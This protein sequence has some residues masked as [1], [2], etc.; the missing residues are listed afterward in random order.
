M[1]SRIT[2]AAIMLASGVA[3]SVAA[4]ITP[5]QALERL[6]SDTDGALLRRSASALELAYTAMAPA[7]GQAAFYAFDR[8]DGDGF[9][10][11]TADDRLPVVLGYTDNGSWQDAMA[12]ENFRTWIA[13]YAEQIDAYFSN[14]AGFSVPSLRSITAERTPIEPLV[15][16]LWNQDAPYNDLCPMDGAQRSM[17]GC[18]AT[19]MAQVLQYHRWPARGQGTNSYYNGDKLITHD[20]T[21]VAFDWDNMLDTY[22]P[23]SYT[24]AQGN[25]VAELML[26]CGMAV[27]MQYT[28]VESGAFSSLLTDNLFKYLGYDM[29]AKYELRAFHSSERWNALIYSELAAGRPVIYDGQ[30]MSGGHC[31][32]C[33]GYSENNLFHINWGW[34]GMANGYYLLS[35]LDP[36]DVGIGGGLGSFNID[37]DA[38]IGIQPP[39]EGTYFRAPVYTYGNATFSDFSLADNDGVMFVFGSDGYIYNYGGHDYEAEMGA[40]I[41]KDGVLLK[42][43][44][45]GV[46][47]TMKGVSPSGMLEPVGNYYIAFPGDV[48]PDGTEYIVCPA[49]KADGCPEWERVRFQN[50]NGQYIY[51]D[52]EDGF[53]EL[54]KPTPSR[55]C[56]LL[57]TDI[58]VDDAPEANQTF[59]V[60]FDVE[61]NDDRG[62]NGSIYLVA[63]DGNGVSTSLQVADLT[64]R[65]DTEDTVTIETLKGLPQ[66]IYTLEMRDELANSMGKSVK[67][68][69]GNA[70]VN[71]IADTTTSRVD[72]YNINGVRV[73]SDV[74]PSQARELLPAGLYIMSNGRKLVK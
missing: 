40:M 8:A 72:V 31:F 22:K 15:K 52:C 73:L 37:Q 67:L 9:T 59:S 6:K 39:V 38:I 50:G 48:M 43:I 57:V 58:R 51:M 3:A 49:V 34:G 66:G 69:V 55:L 12:A 13:S 63:T 26:A 11:L 61:N 30:S 65:R 10:I 18:V 33:D 46:T 23:G 28:S 35:A 74:L 7:N 54:N 29:G 27:N 44:P 19:A 42:T 14:P 16:V 53:I 24:M 68:D 64:M 47:M 41:F 36:V 56:N 32:V 2:L 5:A 20:F 45:S 71:D 25:A 1:K 4:P 62:F 17:T 70:S 21:K 60:T